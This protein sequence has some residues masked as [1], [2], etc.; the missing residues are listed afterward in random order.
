MMSSPFSLN[1][2]TILV[3]GASSGLG[4]AISIKCSEM[5]ASLIL[6]G[7][8]EER[9]KETK[10]MCEGEN[11][12]ISIID[13]NDSNK[14]EEFVKKTQSLNGVINSAGIVNTQLFKFLKED[15]LSDIMNTNFFAPIRIIQ[16][17]IKNKKIT[18]SSSIVFISSISGPEVTYIG[19]SSYSA[20]KAAI[21]G[22]SKTMALELAPKHIR[23]N[24]ILPGMIRT[25][26]LNSI[27]SSTDDLKKDEQ[28][29]PLGYGSPEDVA[30]AAIY[31]LSD[32]SKWVTGINL[33]LDGG[34]T[35]R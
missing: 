8:N 20:S 19:S 2:K 32:A 28:N 6:L 7:R 30:Y 18:N 24:S 12:I 33:K 17:L 11:H 31:L 4:R 13:L 5:G 16:K 35:L 22:I 21:S 14:V 10:D 1:N 3:T 9:L 34:L 15:S 25:K 23:V 27:D 29:Y 26:L